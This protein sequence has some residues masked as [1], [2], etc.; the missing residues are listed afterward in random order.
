MNI[1]S[2]LSTDEMHSLAKS[3]FREERNTKRLD[4]WFIVKEIAKDCDVKFKN[5][6]SAI[7]AAKTLREIAI[8]LP[9]SIS[10]YAVFAGTQNDSFARS[11]ALINP[12]F[13]VDSFTGYCDP[14][15]VLTI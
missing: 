2:F 6:P 4:G 10:E 9:V 13:K 7:K 5:L 15:A 11:Y 12:A 1:Y 8:K 3:R 14:T